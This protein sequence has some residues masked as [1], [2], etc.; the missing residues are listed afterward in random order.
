[1]QRRATLAKRTKKVQKSET[2]LTLST[3]GFED[4]VMQLLFLGVNCKKNGLTFEFFVEYCLTF[5]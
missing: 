2:K 3:E 4:V 5:C 1:M